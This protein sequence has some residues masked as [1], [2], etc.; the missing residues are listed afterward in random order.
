[1]KKI[2]LTAMVLAVACLFAACTKDG[3]YNPKEK[4]SKVYESSS[5]RYSVG[6]NTTTSS[7][8]KHMIENWTWDGKTVK[9]INYYES[10]GELS[11]TINF[12]YDGKRLTKIQETGSDSYTEFTYDGSKL[13][14]FTGYKGANTE[15]DAT[16]T[17]D[18]KKIV[19]IDFVN[20]GDKSAKSPK[21]I[22]MMQTVMQ[23]AM[24]VYTANTAKIMNTIATKGSAAYSLKFEWDGKNISKT[25]ANYDNGNVAITFTYDEMN[26]PF[27]GFFYEMAGENTSSWGSKN[28][29]TSETTVYTEDNESY[30]YTENYTYEYDDKWPTKK[31]SSTV[32]NDEILGTPVTYNY[33]HTTYYEYDD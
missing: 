3:V 16:V 11:Y 28:N 19:Q 2:T 20:Y 12:T 14:K 13:V 26:N 1:M 32:D 15:Y 25:T 30:S 7:V 27:K 24:P 9:S 31:T 21:A 5:Y 6:D 29:V 17:Y 33:T 4:I 18:G 23:I 10:N 8:D 22:R